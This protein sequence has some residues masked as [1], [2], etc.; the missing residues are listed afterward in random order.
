MIT[1][2]FLI[3]MTGFITGEDNIAVGEV[4]NKVMIGQLAGNRNL[5]FGVKN[6]LEEYVME[7]DLMLNPNATKKIDVE[8]LFLDVLTT[9]SNLSVFHK[10]KESVVIRLRGK[11]IKEGKVIKTVIVEESADE[12]SMSTVLID[13]GGTFNQQNLSSALK[14][15][16]KILID[17]LLQ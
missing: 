3:V 11:L 17:K 15:S 5:T 13:E 14:K 2:V 12:I 4:S 16:C 8:I 9:Q 6:M 7:K 1:S 10:N